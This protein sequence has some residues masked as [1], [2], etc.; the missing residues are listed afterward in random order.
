MNESLELISALIGLLDEQ[1][2]QITEQEKAI[3]NLSNE[4]QEIMDILLDDDNVP[5]AGD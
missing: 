5:K 3:D 4:V 2:K 1:D